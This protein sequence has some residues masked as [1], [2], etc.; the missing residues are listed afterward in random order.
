MQ[1]VLQIAHS[2][3]SYWY[4]F[5]CQLSRN[6]QVVPTDLGIV[7]ARQ[8]TTFV[9][10]LRSGRQRP[11]AAKKGDQNSFHSSIFLPFPAVPPEPPQM[12]VRNSVSYRR[13][14]EKT[15]CQQ[16]IFCIRRK[17]SVTCSCLRRAKKAS[18]PAVE[19]RKNGSMAG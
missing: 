18:R 12:N 15:G 4:C 13:Q 11:A 19:S 6:K 1:H 14:I 3:L 16:S 10:R 5:L 7:F 17:I 9:E 8:P 2:Q